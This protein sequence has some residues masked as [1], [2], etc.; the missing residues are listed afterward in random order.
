MLTVLVLRFQN[1]VSDIYSQCI[2]ILWRTITYY[3]IPTSLIQWSW[4]WP[5]RVRSW[6]QC[7]THSKIQTHCDGI[8]F[9]YHTQHS[10]RIH[11]E[12]PAVYFHVHQV[13]YICDCLGV[14]TYK[15]YS[16]AQRSSHKYAVTTVMYG[17]L[18]LLDLGF[19]VHWKIL[20]FRSIRSTG[21]L[22]VVLCVKHERID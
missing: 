18:A 14:W 11:T 6:I 5:L 4:S 7:S 12:L 13:T 10:K 8:T 3:D 9:V 16:A 15:I 1:I 21:L 2:F 19:N 17:E 22:A 20:V